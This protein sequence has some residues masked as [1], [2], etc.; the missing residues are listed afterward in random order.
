MFPGSHWHENPFR[1]YPFWCDRVAETVFT[2]LPVD[3]TK[4][5]DK[6]KL[7]AVELN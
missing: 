5:R 2:R 4:V 1:P 6:E 7:K 3:L